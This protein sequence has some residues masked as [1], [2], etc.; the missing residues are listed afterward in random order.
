MATRKAGDERRRAAQAAGAYLYELLLKKE[1]YYRLWRPRDRQGRPT[2]VDQ[3]AVG[4]VL[5][6]TALERGGEHCPSRHGEYAKEYARTVVRPAWK[7]K[8]SRALNGT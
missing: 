5:N 7:D 8:V 6:R 4:W 1:R 3:G 2:E